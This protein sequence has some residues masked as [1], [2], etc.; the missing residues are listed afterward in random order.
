M[1]QSQHRILIHIPILHSQ[2]DMGQLGFSIRNTLVKKLGERWWRLNAGRVDRFW[3]KI[4]EIVLGLNLVYEKV[5]VYQ[6]GLP[7]CGRET[8]II[9]ELA[10]AGSRN[11]QLLLQLMARGAT[12]MGT[13]SAELLVEEYQ[14][15][16]QLLATE[17][18][19]QASGMSRRERQTLSQGSLRRRD[20]FIAERIDT[21]LQ[22]GETGI[23]FLGMLHSLSG[24]L[25]PDIELMDPF[26]PRSGTVRPWKPPNL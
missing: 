3:S 19:N 11:H 16:T 20:K 8:E 5:R 2:A 26:L 14:L 22:P 21:T 10:A 4:E 23:L 12:V 9:E 13:E 7:I 25:A 17:T 6:D 15:V 18:S 24:L 1:V